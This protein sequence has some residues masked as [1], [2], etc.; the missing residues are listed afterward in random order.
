MTINEKIL[1]L[2]EAK[3]EV[4]QL[5]KA[6]EY[7]MENALR[8]L[9]TSYGYNNLA[10]FI[11]ALKVAVKAAKGKPTKGARKAK[12]SAQAKASVPTKAQKTKKRARGVIND[13]VRATVQT[14]L[15]EGKT[16]AQIAKA[17]K[18]SIPSIQQIK[19]SLGLVKPRKPSAVVAPT[20]A[21]VAE[22][23]QPTA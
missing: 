6:I 18:L 1:K 14:L 19:K 17:T 9:P 8:G 23:A 13:E 2:S 20:P 7:D 21:P 10:D 12:G 5:T 16:G 15:S 3:A 4:A 11:K 22:L